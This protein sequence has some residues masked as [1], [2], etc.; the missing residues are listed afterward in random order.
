MK[1]NLNLH[2][3]EVCDL[4]LAITLVSSSSRAGKW[5]SLHSEIKKQ[6]DAFD[7]EKNKLSK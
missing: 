6:L 2:R 3:Y 5:Q 4:L 1:L 7:E